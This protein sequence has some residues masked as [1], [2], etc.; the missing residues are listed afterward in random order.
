MKGILQEL[1]HLLLQLF[2]GKLPIFRGNG[3][4]GK[5]EEQSRQPPRFLEVNRAAAATEL[6]RL[7]DEVLVQ[8]QE[9]WTGLLV[10]NTKPHRLSRQK[11]V[12]TIVLRVA[13]GRFSVKLI[14]PSQ[15][16]VIFRPSP[17]FHV[18]TYGILKVPDLPDQAILS[19]QRQGPD[20]LARPS[21]HLRP[22][23]PACHS[24]CSWPLLIELKLLL[25]AVT[26]VIDL[27]QA[28]GQH[29]LPIFELVHKTSIFLNKKAGL[30]S[31][32]DLL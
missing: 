24:P 30:L 27:E 3:L 19:A 16:L 23:L 8:L 17:E 32:D 1:L 29:F 6:P 14:N 25:H 2:L 9:L 20:P 22:L 21:A 26:A 31:K 10:G 18:G 13:L 4:P 28:E 5:G 11:S 7:G 15:A 12:Q